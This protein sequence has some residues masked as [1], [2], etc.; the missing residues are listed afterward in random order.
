MHFI[1]PRH[2]DS[3]WSCRVLRYLIQTFAILKVCPTDCVDSPGFF[4]VASMRFKVV[5]VSEISWQLLDD[6]H[7]IWYRRSSFS[8]RRLRSCYWQADSSRQRWPNRGRSWPAL[9]GQSP[10]VAL[11]CCSCLT[12]NV[13]SLSVLF[14]YDMRVFFFHYV[15][16]YMRCVLFVCWQFQ[17]LPSFSCFTW[18]LRTVKGHDSCERAKRIQLYFFIFL[19]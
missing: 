5:A 17:S 16:K 15:I 12:S 10:S 18:I 8:T 11:T 7:V 3:V 6:C 14:T 1:P 19:V 13:D 9:N 2:K 4:S